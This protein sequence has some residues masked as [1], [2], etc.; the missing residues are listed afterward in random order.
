MFLSSENCGFRSSKDLREEGQLFEE[1]VFQQAT[2]GSL[3][4]LQG[5]VTSS[6]SWTALSKMS[7]IS[8]CCWKKPRSRLS[9]RL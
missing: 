4:C 6:L 9:G 2:P 1:L 5:E 7:T 8:T 3:F